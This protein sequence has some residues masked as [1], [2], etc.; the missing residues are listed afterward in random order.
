MAN[1]IP[2]AFSTKAID[3]YKYELHKSFIFDT[4]ATGHVCNDRS[5]F[6]D[7]QPANNTVVFDLNLVG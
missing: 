1:L 4:G 2:A 5:R 3:I 6:I 7:F